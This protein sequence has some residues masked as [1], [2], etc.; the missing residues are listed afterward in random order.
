[1]TRTLALLACSI[2]LFVSFATSASALPGAGEASRLVAVGTD[3]RTLTC[4]TAVHDHRYTG[5]TYYRISGSTTCGGAIEQSCTLTLP[6]DNPADTVFLQDSVFGTT[7][8]LAAGANGEN[9]G[10]LQYRTIVHAPA[11]MVWLGVPVQCSGA[12]TATLD[13]TFSTGDSPL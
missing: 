11:G 9:W 2:T 10:A 3:G 5:S 1:M 12:G 7:C 6:N 8:S 13:C 4:S